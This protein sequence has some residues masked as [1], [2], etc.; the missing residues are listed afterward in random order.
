MSGSLGWSIFTYYPLFQRLISA[1]Y[2]ELLTIQRDCDEIKLNHAEMM[3]IPTP[4][5]SSAFSMQRDQDEVSFA[6]C[7][8]QP[9][10]NVEKSIQSFDGS[11]NNVENSALFLSLSRSPSSPSK[12]GKI[13][14][15][16]SVEGPENDPSGYYCGLSYVKKV[17]EDNGFASFSPSNISP[18]PNR[19]S[20]AVYIDPSP[21]TNQATASAQLSLLPVHPPSSSISH[22]KANL[23]SGYPSDLSNYSCETPPPVS[24]ACPESVAKHETNSGNHGDQVNSF[25]STYQRGFSFNSNSWLG[26]SASTMTLPLSTNRFEPISPVSYYSSSSSQIESSLSDQNFSIPFHSGQTNYNGYAPSEEALLNNMENKNMKFSSFSRPCDGD[27]NSRDISVAKD[28]MSAYC[29]S[30]DRD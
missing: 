11:N 23:K 13:Y 8:E 25:D 19:P 7:C 26:P 5:T 14:H 29:S 2:E 27:I 28:F 16:T 6:N 10:G 24:I 21:K 4:T 20:V 22:E 12:K 1:Q 18:H 9:V 3:D 17:H 15:Q 30:H